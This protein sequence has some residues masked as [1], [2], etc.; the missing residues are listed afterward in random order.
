MYSPFGVSP[1]RYKGHKLLDKPMNTEEFL[2]EL[3]KWEKERVEAL[4]C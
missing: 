1:E 3:E 4:K 2:Q